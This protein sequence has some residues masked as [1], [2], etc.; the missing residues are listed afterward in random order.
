MKLT[1]F[2]GREIVIYGAGHVGRKFFR[3]LEER[4]FGS[5]VRCFAVTG[6]RKPGT[7]LE[8]IPLKCIY[9]IP[10]LDNTLICLA[11]H[12]TLREELENTVREITD[13]YVWIYPYLYSLMFGEPE[14]TDMEINISEILK[15]CRRDERIAVRLAAIEQYEGKNTFGY[16][17][18]K[19]AQ[20]MHCAEHTAGQRLQQFKELMADWKENGYRKEYPLSLNRACEVID[21]NHR[22]ALAVYYH[23]TSIL[24][25]IYPT[26]IPLTEIHGKEPIM[27]KIVLEQHGFTEEEIQ[28]LDEL[29]ERYVE[30]YGR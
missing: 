15:T 17:Y 29:Q 13:R 19:R 27:P 11:V 9:D 30:I 14:Q 1:D 5:Q 22:L 7:V 21:G 12:E 24:C 10:I 2:E 16:E 6:Q 18:Y 8:G 20:M 4:G 28:R 26:E 25:N 3:T 23:Q